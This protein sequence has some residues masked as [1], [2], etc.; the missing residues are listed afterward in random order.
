MRLILDVSAINIVHLYYIL[1]R[2]FSRLLLLFYS[3]QY[4]TI[5]QLR[6]E[7]MQTGFAALRKLL[8]FQLIFILLLATFHK[9]EKLF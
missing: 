5:M 2:P 1:R 6:G 4:N 3:V 7:R 8:R 9:T